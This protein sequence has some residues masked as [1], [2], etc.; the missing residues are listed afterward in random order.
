MKYFSCQNGYDHQTFQG[1]EMLRGAL[2]HKY[3][4]HLNGVVLWDHVTDEVHVSTRKRCI[5]ITLGKLPT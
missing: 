5:D 4:W 2:T 1:G 3:V